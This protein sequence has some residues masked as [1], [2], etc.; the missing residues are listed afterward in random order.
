M[1]QFLVDEFHFPAVFECL[2]PFVV[3]DI[4]NPSRE[5]DVS[6]LHVFRN[7]KLPIGNEVRLPN[8]CDDFGGDANLNVSTLFEL[9]IIAIFIR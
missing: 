9:H 4:R 3:W 2:D 7:R 8:R 5:V 6:Q 1:R